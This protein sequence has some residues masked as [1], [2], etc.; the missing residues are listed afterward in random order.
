MDVGTVGDTSVVGSGL[1]EPENSKGL[2]CRWTRG[3]ADLTMP[4]PG[5]GEDLTLSMGIYVGN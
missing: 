1:W 2:C 4:D 5:N 3:V